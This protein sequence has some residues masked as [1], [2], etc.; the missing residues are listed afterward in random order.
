MRALSK[1]NY[2]VEQTQHLSDWHNK[3]LKTATPA[4]CCGQ[5]Q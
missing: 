5:G 1:L 4:W 3:T 2:S